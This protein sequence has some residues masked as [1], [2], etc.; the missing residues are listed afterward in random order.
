[1]RGLE[2]R[3]AVIVGHAAVDDRVEPGAELADRLA[4]EGRA[5]RALEDEGRDVLRV[6]ARDP[7]PCAREDRAPVTPDEPRERQPRRSQHTCLAGGSDVVDEIVIGEALKLALGSLSKVSAAQVS[8]LR[9]VVRRVSDAPVRSVDKIRAVTVEPRST[10]ANFTF[11]TAAGGLDF[12][13]EVPGGAPYQRDPRAVDAVD[14]GA[15]RSAS[16]GD[17]LIRMKRA[18]G[19]PVDRMTSQR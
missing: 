9:S 1:V 7:Q 12:F 19:R 8:L 6:V 14:V 15:F 16:R 3:P 13:A 18:A 4:V 11:Q 5:D 2:T 17:D 10:G